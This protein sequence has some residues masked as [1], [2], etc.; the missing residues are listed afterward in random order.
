MSEHEKYM[1]LALKVAHTHEKE[2]EALVGSVI[3]RDGEVVATGCNTAKRD[4]DM[5]AHA[6]I[7]AMKNAG[8]AQGHTDLS[9]CTLYSTGEPCI[10]CAGA[11]VSAG[12]ARVVLGGN[13]SKHNGGFGDY[14]V[15]KAFAFVNR[16][17]IE[18]VRGVLTAECEAMR[19]SYWARQA[20]GE[21]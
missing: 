2:G 18:V 5:T 21:V 14:S 10:M 13:Y 4:L 9:G 6:E 7:A 19:W 12:I 17:D 3:V 16:N 15:E 11:M 8:P 20:R 1:R